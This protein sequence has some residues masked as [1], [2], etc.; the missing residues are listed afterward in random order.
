MI[1]VG[2]SD[3]QVTFI[4]MVAYIWNNHDIYIYIYISGGFCTAVWLVGA[5]FTH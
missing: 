4:I 5:D 2:A 1:I 3:V